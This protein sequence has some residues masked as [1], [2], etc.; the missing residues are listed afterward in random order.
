MEIESSTT[1]GGAK[2]SHQLLTRSE[3]AQALKISVSQTYNLQNSKIIPCIRVTSR[4]IR[5][6]WDAV[7]KALDGRTL[8]IAGKVAA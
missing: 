6:D 5:F 2:A 8:Q 7:M 4:L 3:L 1:V